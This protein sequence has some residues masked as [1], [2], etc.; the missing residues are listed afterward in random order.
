MVEALSLLREEDSFL[1][2]QAADE[3]GGPWLTEACAPV[4]TLGTLLLHTHGSNVLTLA[5]FV[6]T[7]FFSHQ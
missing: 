3:P 2:T 4:P 1:K 7:I 6:Q 5:A